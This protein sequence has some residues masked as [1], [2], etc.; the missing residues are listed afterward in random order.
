VKKAIDIKKPPE[1]K[2]PSGREHLGQ[3][4]GTLEAIRRI[5]MLHEIVLRFDFAPGSEQ[6]LNVVRQKARLLLS[7]DLCLVGLLNRGQTH[8][9]LHSLSPSAD[10]AGVHHHHMSVEEAFFGWVIDNQSPVILELRPGPSAG[11]DV[12]SRIRKAGMRT[13]LTV[14]M[15]A[16]NDAVGFL[17]FG[18]TSEEVF[19][20]EDIGLAQLFALYLAT[21]LR[22]MTLLDDTRRR[23]AQIESINAISRRVAS[24]L[25]LEEL[26]G[27]AVESIQKDFQ[28]FDITIFLLSEDKSELILEAHSGN[29]AD[30]I[31]HRYRQP[32]DQGIVG[33]VASSGKRMMVNDVSKEPRFHSTGSHATKSELVLP[34]KIDSEVVGVLNVED[35]KLYAFD[36]TDAVVLE[37]VCEQ[38]GSAMKNA[39]LYDEI[40]RVN[41]KLTEMDKVK[42]EFLGIVSHDFRTPIANIMLSGK[43][44]LKNEDIQKNPR[45]RDQLRLI[46]DQA[47]R[48]SKLADDTL[49]ISRIESGQME[50]SFKIVNIERLIQ[51]AISQIQHSPRH[52]L[53]YK[54]DFNATYIKGDQIKLRQVIQNLVNNAVKYSP[55]GG[56]VAVSAQDV[57][58]ETILVS[59]KDEGLGIPPE[60]KDKLFQKFSRVNE[61]EASK[62]TGSGLGLW[63][64]K[65]VVVAHGGKIWF[66]SEVGKGTTFKFTL[67]KSH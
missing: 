54:V 61:G 2:S 38:I 9:V 19:T 27:V 13:L 29:F 56:T 16:G 34:I 18:S 6:I 5:Y 51:D 14:P 12:E 25:N 67:K 66:E 60:Q 57:T 28:Y 48:L 65:E 62:M 31:P 50:Y 39:K 24:K 10:A 17:A 42:S 4:G 40:R 20:E 35:T 22:N 52:K 49:S 45:V 33:C 41:V 43:Y 3:S 58:E 11:S 53:E 64:C 8:F 36:E 44:V 30:L 46:V 59:V 63:I 15:R 7:F 1:E 23:M 21:S 32:L 26:L 47:Q 55:R 37:T